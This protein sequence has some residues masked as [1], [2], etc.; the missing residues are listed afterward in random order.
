MMLAR[1]SHSLGSR[2]SGKRG[3]SAPPSSTVSCCAGSSTFTLTLR[4]WY[5][6]KLCSVLLKE[7]LCACRE[8]LG[9]CP[10][11]AAGSTGARRVFMRA[12]P[13]PACCR[14]CA[15][16]QQLHLRSNRTS[17]REQTVHLA[18]IVAA[19]GEDAH[20]RRPSGELVRGQRLVH[21]A[22]PFI[23]QSG[24]PTLRENNYIYNIFF[25]E[26]RAA[27]ALLQDKRVKVEGAA[28]SRESWGVKT[29]PSTRHTHSDR[30]WS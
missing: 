8:V 22:Q 14:S 19:L 28:H 25:G 21:Q 17:G 27:E 23:R 6:E 12:R 13:T 2:T 30:T 15:A 24:E 20:N 26:T 11:A 3:S 5:T 16:Q 4:G 7:R 29:L 18:H 1:C 9:A 10:A